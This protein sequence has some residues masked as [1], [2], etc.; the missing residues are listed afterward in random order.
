MKAFRFS[1]LFDS[2]MPG[3]ALR[4]Y[5]FQSGINQILT[6]VQY[7]SSSVVVQLN[8][9][10]LVHWLYSSIDRCASTEAAPTITA[11]PMV[12]LD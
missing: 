9:S 12:R 3:L 5:L 8:R 6:P 2:F 11:E 7:N 10:L 4:S 1:R